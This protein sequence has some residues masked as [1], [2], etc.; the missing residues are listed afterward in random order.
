MWEGVEYGSK[1]NLKGRAFRDLNQFAPKK[2]LQRLT[3]CGGLL[4]EV[5]AGFRRDVANRNDGHD[6]IMHA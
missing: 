1:S 4:L 6:C 5:F 3:S 2:L